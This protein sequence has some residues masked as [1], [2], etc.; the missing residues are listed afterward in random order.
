MRHYDGAT[1]VVLWEQM[2][3]DGGR[4]DSLAVGQR[5][6]IGTG[7][8]VRPVDSDNMVFGLA[9]RLTGRAITVKDTPASPAEGQILVQSKDPLFAPPAPTGLASDPT[10]NGA[11][12]TLVNPTTLE[13]AFV[14]LPAAN[15]SASVATDKFARYT[16]RYSDPGGG[17][18]SCKALLKS[19]GKLKVKCRGTTGGFT[20]DEASQGSLQAELT[21]GSGGYR[22]CVE[23]GGDVTVDVGSGGTGRGLFKARNAPAA[24]ACSGGF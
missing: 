4:M 8:A 9:A 23:F 7:L 21:I 14:A 17:V 2:V 20:L 5:A 1:G 10:V 18:P 13:S 24:G 16:Y 19:P 15:W 6:V 3:L 22:Y 12:L 11:S